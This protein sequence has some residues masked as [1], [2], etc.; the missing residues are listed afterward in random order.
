MEA[1]ERCMQ[2]QEKVYLAKKTKAEKAKARV[3]ASLD[4]LS[5]EIVQ[6]TRDSRKALLA[7]MVATP[8][9]N[10][11]KILP[12]STSPVSGY[13]FYKTSDKAYTLEVSVP[14][15]TLADL[16]I[17]ISR[18]VLEI[19]LATQELSIFGEPLI[20]TI[21]EFKNIKFQVKDCLV[22]HA[23]VGEGILMIK[24]LKTDPVVE[25]DVII[26]I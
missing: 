6:H 8:N 7:E 9:Q 23:T 26:L 20:R 17:N 12:E 16:S 13:N 25:E 14:G 3:Q 22:E 15:L 24:L 19:S 18:N 21:N 4:S 2:E 10:S 1:T 11:P 5:E